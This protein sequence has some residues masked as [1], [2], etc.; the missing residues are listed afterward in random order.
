MQQINSS[1]SSR[2]MLPIVM[3]MIICLLFSGIQAAMAQEDSLL[4]ISSENRNKRWIRYSDSANALY[5]HISGQAF[6]HLEKRSGEVAKIRTIEQWRDRQAEVRKTFAD[7]IGPFPEKAPLNVKITGVLHKD[8]Y[9]VEKTIYESRPGYYVTSALFVPDGLKGKAP[10]ILFCIGHSAAAFRRPLYQH[11][12][13]N[14]VKKGFVVLAIDPIGQGERLQYYDPEEGASLIGGSTLEHSYP[15]AQCFIS[16][17]SI[18]ENFIW[19]GIRGIDYLLSREEVDPD[20]IGC[21]GLSGGGTQSSYIAAFDD[22]VK[23]VA[24]AGFIT[25]LQRLLESIGPQ[26]G[27][28]NMY[29]DIFR[30]IDHADLLA[31]RA[32]KPALMVTTTGDFFSIQGSR[33]TFEELKRVYAAYGK[34]DNIG[35]VEDDYGHGYTRKNREAIYAFFQKHLNLPGNPIDEEVEYLTPEE[36]TITD[37]GQ[38]STSLGG[39]TAFS[40][41]ASESLE[42]I[43]NLEDSRRNLAEHLPVVKNAAQRLSGYQK[44]GNDCEALF[45]GRLHRD[46]YTIEKYFM[47]GEGD[48]VIPFVMMFPESKGPHPAVL[49]L[50]PDGKSADADPGGRMEWLV[51]KGYAVLAPDLIGTGEMGPGIYQGDAYNFKVGKANYNLWFAALRIGRSIAGIRAGDTVRLINFLKSRE[52]VDSGKISAVALGS[53][54][55]VLLHAAVFEQTLGRITL[56]EPLVSY[57]SLVM[58]RYYRPDFMINAV[59]GALTAYD[60][61]DLAACLAPRELVMVNITDQ[62]GDQAPSGVVEEDMDI[63]R[64]AFS[65][66]GKQNNFRI[67]NIDSIDGNTGEIFSAW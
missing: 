33:E 23:A 17:K 60:L 12:A 58:N 30:G 57:R 35:M 54:C 6:T 19:D 4:V 34:E 59:A 49:Y 20:R 55:P 65:R 18:A 66:A 27:E 28:Q 7:I 64:S 44:P 8:G 21:H 43:E 5:H 56:I 31:V 32:P 50:H 25:S 62:N 2:T 67:M 14:L 48:Y 40:I 13:L 39:E 51:R 16:G 15:A 24:P 10:A 36:L 53:M 37:T 46:G 63:V 38:I 52:N 41:N 9:R 1:C 61:P 45:T 11:V 26:D 47:Q 42:L 22:R 29:Q 3:L